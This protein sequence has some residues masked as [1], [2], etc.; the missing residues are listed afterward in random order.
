MHDLKDRF[1][2]EL[3]HVLDKFPK[4]HMKFLLGNFIAKEGR[5]NIFKPI[6][7]NE[8]LHEIGNDNGIK[9][10]KFATSKNLIV[11][12]VMFSHR[13]IHTFIRHLLIVR[14]TVKL[15]IF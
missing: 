9:V 12:G 5:E 1:Y 8:N 15:A 11:N 6:T 4:Y 2:E 13:N 10:V 14:L 3:E 7:G